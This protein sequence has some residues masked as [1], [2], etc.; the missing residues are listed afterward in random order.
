M[1]G[2]RGRSRPAA[3]GKTPQQPRTAAQQNQ[4]TSLGLNLNRTDAPRASRT[5][6]T[7]IQCLGLTSGIVRGRVPFFWIRVSVRGLAA[8]YFSSAFL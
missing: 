1:A 6:R 5:P 8:S 7:G 4:S 3:K 2:C